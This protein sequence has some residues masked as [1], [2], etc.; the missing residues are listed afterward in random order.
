M[1]NETLCPVLSV[2]NLRT[3]FDTNEGVV[4][5][6]D[7]VSFDL[8]EGR[9]LGIVGESGCGKSITSLSIMGLIPT[10]PGWIESD[11]ILF[12]GQDLLTLSEDEMNMIRGNEIAMIFQEP[13]TSLNPVMQV[14]DQI[15]E[16]LLLHKPITATE[17]KSRTIDLM[18]QVKIPNAEKRYYE[19]P[20]ELSGG[21][22]QRVMIA[23]ALSCEPEILICDEPTTA[24]DVTIQAQI[25]ELIDELKQTYKSTIMMITH[26]MGVIAQMAD[27]VIVMYGGKAVECAP[28]DDLFYD[29]LHPYTQ[30]LL[31]SIPKLHKDEPLKSIR[32]VV[33]KASDMPCGCSFHPRCDFAKEICQTQPP[34]VS[35]ADGRKVT[36]WRYA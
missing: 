4:K 12:K 16:A 14:G 20:H 25:L 2:R 35:M 22:R 9:T 30:A 19:F 27:E 11:G 34:E 6:V 8:H 15:A 32:G 17:A 31:D 21:M 5:S 29:P 1:Q 36:C 28:V 7:G 33:P 26:D 13:M 23:M 24:L 10:P 18:R 3:Y